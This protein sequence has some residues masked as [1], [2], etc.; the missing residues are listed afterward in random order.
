MLLKERLI[1]EAEHRDRTKMKNFYP[2]GINPTSK[3]GICS[4]L[5]FSWVNPVLEHS[6]KYQCNID[7]MGSVRLKDDVFV[8]KAKL[9][10]KWD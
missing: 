3:A 4:R 8:Q 9:E 7:D 6:K 1:A 10:R 2:E 5:F